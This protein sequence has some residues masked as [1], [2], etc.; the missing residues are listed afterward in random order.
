MYNLYKYFLQLLIDIYDNSHVNIPSKINDE[1]YH[2]EIPKSEPIDQ[3]SN[4]FN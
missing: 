4:K 2:Q 1:T 3:F